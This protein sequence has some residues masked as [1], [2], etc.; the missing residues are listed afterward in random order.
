MEE[1]ELKIAIDKI[2]E[3]LWNP[4]N[5]KVTLISED[6]KEFSN[7]ISDFVKKTNLKDNQIFEVFKDLSNWKKMRKIF[8]ELDYDGKISFLKRIKIHLDKNSKFNNNQKLLQNRNEIIKIISSILNEKKSLSVT[9]ESADN[10]IKDILNST[11]INYQKDNL[12]KLYFFIKGEKDNLKQIFNEGLLDNFYIHFNNKI[13]KI[14]KEKDLLS[15]LSQISTVIFYL[16]F[17]KYIKN[18]NKNNNNNSNNNIF[19]IDGAISSNKNK[20]GL[21][22]I[23]DQKGQLLSKKENSECEWANEIEAFAFLQFVKYLIK[24]EIDN[25]LVYE[26]NKTIISWIKKGKVNSKTKA[27]DYMD[28]SFKLINNNHLQIKV[29]YIESNSNLAD[30]YTREI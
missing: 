5:G 25:C 3:L 6:Y 18:L 27:K 10:L 9:N 22:I 14:A 8:D 17:A 12:K 16:D 7:F 24:N 26:D 21:A 23:A 29:E 19:Y 28:Q 4:K 1:Y 13:K 30:K 20:I 15:F 11:D 2:L